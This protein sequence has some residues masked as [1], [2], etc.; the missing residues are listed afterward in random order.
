VR[1]LGLL[2]LWV[3]TL[4]QSLDARLTL[5][6]VV[7]DTGGP[8][9]R[10][11]G[12]GDVFDHRLC[13]RAGWVGQVHASGAAAGNSKGSTADGRGVGGDGT[14]AAACNSACQDAQGGAQ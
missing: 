5:C 2:V 10:R 12:A 7:L 6:T 13:F 8:A 3:Y 1:A 14:A 11:C 9:A 4:D